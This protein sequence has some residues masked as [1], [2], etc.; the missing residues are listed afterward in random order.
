MAARK[1]TPAPPEAAQGLRPETRGEQRKLGNWGFDIPPP[2]HAR[3]KAPKKSWHRPGQGINPALCIE[4]AALRA[5]VV[6]LGEAEDEP[7]VG[8]ILPNLRIDKA[9]PF[10]DSTLVPAQ[11]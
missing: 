6:G 8:R 5:E 7:I 10:D 2:P 1:Q 3:N 4:P 11:R 9:T